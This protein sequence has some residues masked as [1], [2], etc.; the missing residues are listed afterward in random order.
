MKLKTGDRVR[1]T[2]G[3]DKGKEGKITQ[4]FPAMDRVV[5][6]GANTQKRHLRSRG[7]STPGQIIEFPSPLHVSN[8]ALLSPKSGKVG[9]VG[10]TR[11]TKDGKHVKIRHLRKGGEREDIE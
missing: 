10:Y 3:K 2:A 1:V 11:L 9:R 8:V 6:E 4:V 7:A 5:V